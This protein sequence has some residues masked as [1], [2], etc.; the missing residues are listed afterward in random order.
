QGGTRNQILNN[1][2]SGNQLYGVYLFSGAD[3]NTISSN[4]ITNN[5]IHGIYVKTGHNTIIANVVSD[6][7]PNA[8]GGATGSGISFLHETPAAA[9][10]AAPD[11]LPLAATPEDSATP[12]L[13]SDVVGNRVAQ[14]VVM[15]NADEGI[16]I[17]NAV[18][19]SVE[20]NIIT[21][22]RSNGIYL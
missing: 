2:V 7:G 9:G 14:N 8:I 11:T 6:N 15:R 13:I 1:I 22:N 21:S 4:I 19:T 18:G 5:G 17:K 12:A 3:G 20:A 10:A 16:E